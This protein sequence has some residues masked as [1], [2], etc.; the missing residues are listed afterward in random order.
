MSRKQQNKGPATTQF[1]AKVRELASR[2]VDRMRA[3]ELVARR[4]PELHRMMICE[5]NMGSTDATTLAAVLDGSTAIHAPI[6]RPGVVVP[7][8]Q[9]AAKPV[10]GTTTRSPVTQASAIPA[11]PVAPAAADAEPRGARFNYDPMF[12]PYNV[13]FSY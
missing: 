6:Q 5:T 1:D 13:G 8:K 9:S 7:S 10:A 12:S 11:A 4:N 2:G 3:C